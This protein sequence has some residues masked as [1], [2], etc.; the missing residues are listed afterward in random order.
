MSHDRSLLPSPDADTADE[1]HTASATAHL[2]D[3]LSL[4]GHRFGQDAPDP[5][6][7]PEAAAVQSQL[8]AMVESFAAMLNGTRLED[9]LADLFSST[10]S[11]ARPIASSASS[12]S[13]SR[14]SAAARPNRTAPRS[15]RS[16]SNGSGDYRGPRV[17]GVLLVVARRD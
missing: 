7:L 17:K 4:Y 9:D 5:R 13:T 8:D 12:T 2:L 6:P 3:E 14:H 11:T 10:C 16:S 1:H 15:S